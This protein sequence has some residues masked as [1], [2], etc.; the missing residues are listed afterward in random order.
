MRVR[1]RRGKEEAGARGAVCKERVS[2]RAELIVAASSRDAT[3]SE[4]RAATP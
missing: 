4:A 1:G 2:L 3:R